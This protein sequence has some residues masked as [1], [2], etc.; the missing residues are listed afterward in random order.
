MVTLYLNKFFLIRKTVNIF[1]DA[2]I[3]FRRGYICVFI[4]LNILNIH[5][6]N[7]IF[8]VT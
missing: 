7:N 8:F 3:I 6:R 1:V 2:I 4:G 5:T